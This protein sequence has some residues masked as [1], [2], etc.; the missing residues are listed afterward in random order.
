MSFTEL[1]GGLTFEAIYNP[2]ELNEILEANWTELEVL[3]LSH[4]PQQYQNTNPHQF[5]FKLEFDAYADGKNRL[6]DILLWRR[7]LLSLFYAPRGSQDVI[8]GSP[9]RF[10]FVWPNFIALT[11]VIHRA[12]FTHKRF[13]KDGQPTLFEVDV[14]IK[15]IRDVRLLADEALG[16]G[17]FRGGEEGIGESVV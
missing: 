10:L 16:D 5:T 17:T 2:E 1:R 11:C 8:G 7:F 3:G 12:E 4:K 9:T 6:V 14:T 15:E 13:N